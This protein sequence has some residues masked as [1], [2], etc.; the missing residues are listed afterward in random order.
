MGVFRYIYAA[1]IPP[2]VAKLVFDYRFTL[3]ETN[4]MDIDCK[5]LRVQSSSWGWG[6]DIL[7]KDDIL[8]LN[9][10]HFVL[11]MGIVDVYAHD[12][13]TMDRT[14]WGQDTVST[15]CTD[16]SHL[17]YVLMDNIVWIIDD[18]ETLSDIR[19]ASPGYC[20][21][22]GASGN[23]AFQWRF[24]FYP[25]GSSVKFRNEAILSI[26]L[27]AMPQNVS[28]ISVYFELHIEETNTRWTHCSHFRPHHLSQGWETAR[29]KFEAICALDKVTLRAKMYLVDVFDSE[30]D[31]VT[32]QFVKQLP[33]LPDD[34]QFVL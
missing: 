33:D 31:V 16:S 7:K 12:G 10:F 13:H 3:K 14:E 15:E 32:Q 26:E 29:V 11:E 24:L 2:K 27:M 34:G 18:E 5:E 23:T 30:G 19:R 25:N 20:L 17:E 22:N 21:M 9:A 28:G 4:A 6:N 1:C 8:S